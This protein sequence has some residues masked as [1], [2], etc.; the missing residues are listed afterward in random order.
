MKEEDSLNT[1]PTIGG[2]KSF[3]KKPKLIEPAVKRLGTTLESDE[4][5]QDLD[6]GKIADAGNFFFQFNNYKYIFNI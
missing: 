4:F 5:I 2:T 3:I 1:S 6:T